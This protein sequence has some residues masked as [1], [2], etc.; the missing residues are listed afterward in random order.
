[1][2][3]VQFPS[4]V[5]SN[6]CTLASDNPTREGGGGVNPIPA[7]RDVRAHRANLESG[8]ANGVGLATEVQLRGEALDVHRRVHDR[9]G[10]LQ[11]QVLDELL[12][13]LHP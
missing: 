12:E 7:R 6:Y 1:M 8:H 3:N 10:R 13:G 2:L 9:Y 5:G 4:T 11:I